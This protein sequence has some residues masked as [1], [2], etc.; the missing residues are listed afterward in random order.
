MH[1]RGRSSSCLLYGCLINRSNNVFNS[2]RLFCHER[3]FNDNLFFF[4]YCQGSNRDLRWP[5]SVTTKDKNSRQKKNFRGKRKMLAAKKKLVTAKEKCSRQK[6]NWSRQK[7]K[8]PGKRKILAA[9]KKLVTAK[10]KSSRQKK[11]CCSKRK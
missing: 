11:N 10:E 4:H 3:N 8:A 1:W 6:R 9:K 2:E 7:K 5:T